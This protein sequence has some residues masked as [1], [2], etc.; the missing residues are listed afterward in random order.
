MSD[1]F[2]SYW[3]FLAHLPAKMRRLFLLSGAIY[4]G[5]AIGVELA[6]GYYLNFYGFELLSA[7][8]DRLFV[9]SP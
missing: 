4:I 6:H 2:Q 8:L 7:P 9:G 1:C 5:G 3:K